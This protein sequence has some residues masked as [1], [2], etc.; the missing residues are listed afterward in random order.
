M[1]REGP[2]WDRPGPEGGSCL[3]R[4]LGVRLL[5]PT[6]SSPMLGLPGPAS[7][8]LGPSS[9]N[10][11]GYRYTPPPPTLVPIPRIPVPRHARAVA[12]GARASSVTGACTYGR[13]EHPVGE[14]RGIEYRGI[15]RVPGWFIEV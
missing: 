3:Q 11:A 1:T 10:V 9:S 6:H 14:P 4:T 13:F 2:A 8:V 7:L 5:E 12:S 15:F